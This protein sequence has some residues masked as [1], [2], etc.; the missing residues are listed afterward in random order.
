IVLPYGTDESIS[1]IRSMADELA[2]V[3]VEPVQSRRP[4][5]RPR[6]FIREVREI[7]RQSG[8]LF[9]FDEVVTGFRFGP[10]GAQDYYGVD[11]DLAT[12][13]KVVGGGMPVGVVSGKAEFMDT[14]DGG[15]W[16]YGDESFPEK[17]VTFFAGTFV[18]HPLAMAS[19]KA[20]LS[21]FREQPL[22]FWQALN[23]K[24]DRL[25]GTVHRLFQDHH[26]PYEL[27]NRGSLLFA[28]VGEDQ[29]YGNLLFY[30]LRERGVYLLEG[31]PSYLTASHS[32]DDVDHVIEAFRSSAAELQEAGFFPESEPILSPGELPTQATPT[33]Y[34]SVGK[35]P[36]IELEPGAF[37]IPTT[38][39]QREIVVA[40]SMSDTASCAFNE[41]ASL[42]LEGSLDD[43]A[44]RT[45]I[46]RLTER[47]DALRATF[48]EDG[49]TMRIHRDLRIDFDHSQ[50]LA[51][52][53][54]SEASTPFDL[55]EGP[56]MRMRL[57]RESRECH[58]LVMNAHHAIVDGWSYNVIAEEL[59]AFYNAAVRNE[60]TRF[61]E[62]KQFAEHAREQARFLTSN[63]WKEQQNF[64]LNQFADIPPSITLPLDQPY[65]AERTF[66]GGTVTH[67]IGE[68][69]HRAIKKAGAEEGATLYGTLSA[70]F[71][72]FLHRICRQEELVYCIP[73]AGQNDGDN[74]DNLIGHCVNFLPLR[75][76]LEDKESF[77]SFL[78]RNRDTFLA[79]TDH[80]SYTYGELIR[81]LKIERDP[82]RMPLSEVAFN[83][84]RMD[85]FGDWEDLD[86][87][88]KPNAKAH[89]HYSLFLN[90]VE[91]ESGLRLDFDFNGEILDRSTI[92]RWAHQFETLVESV[93]A[94]ISSPTQALPLLSSTERKT[95]LED[96]SGV[97]RLPEN[98][99]SVYEIF[100]KVTSEYP[101]KTA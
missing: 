15:G 99:P 90:I 64:W 33:P 89:V 7:T 47:H 42:L 73:A 8:T 1:V 51:E 50:D 14:F 31:F 4:E 10:G 25:A 96:W 23:A 27:P 57:V 70:V 81:D 93:A 62:P 43:E 101:D 72:L 63:T 52:T 22:H 34:L 65:P 36:P 85:Y 84:E 76:R 40:S 69:T 94:D 98:L 97:S 29:P 53:L 19:L 32:D 46:K 83:L 48:S 66:A 58:T 9:V 54:R 59:S 11:A 24:G 28:R 79:A 68:K 49:T 80:R 60:S 5:F 2:A 30:H 55:T 71:A 35:E 100:E 91:S 75:S 18:R 16:N 13:G 56:L 21:F 92:E 87:A 88:F 95:I 38:Q 20:M 74:T 45:A 86:V 12:Y 67:R 82:R 61:A 77:A 6:D 44:L 41:S 78:K 26:L 39:P 17:P 3:I 37:E